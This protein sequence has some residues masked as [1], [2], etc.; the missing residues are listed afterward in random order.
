MRIQEKASDALQQSCEEYVTKI[1]ARTQDLSIH[2]GAKTISHDDLLYTIEEFLPFY[3]KKH[4]RYNMLFMEPRKKSSS[5]NNK[6]KKKEKKVKEKKARKP[7]VKAAPSVITTTEVD[8]VDASTAAS[9][10]GDEESSFITTS[11]NDMTVEQATES[12]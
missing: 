12:V 9:T 1:F 5:D 4:S 10:A 11:I 2:R 8:E 6:G 3:P 7:K